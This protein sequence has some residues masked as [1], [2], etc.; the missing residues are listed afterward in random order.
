MQAAWI[1]S[2]FEKLLWAVKRNMLQLVQVITFSSRLPS[3]S[4]LLPSYMH[5]HIIVNFKK[6]YPWMCSL[7]RLFTS[8]SFPSMNQKKK[9]KKYSYT[10]KLILSFMWL[11]YD[12][13]RQKSPNHSCWQ[14]HFLKHNHN[15]IVS[16][17]FLIAQINKKDV[18]MYCNWLIIQILIKYKHICFCRFVR[19]IR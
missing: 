10:K 3:Y 16:L 4:C 6:T 13:S 15:L 14:L 1:E 8:S 9:G 7:C 11:W 18:S 2:T 5:M 12:S 17:D 19:K